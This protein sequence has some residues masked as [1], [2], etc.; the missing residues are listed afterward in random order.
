M[1]WPI[2]HDGIALRVPRDTKLCTGSST[3]RTGLQIKK[4][5]IT[6]DNI[7]LE[8]LCEQIV[9]SKIVWNIIQPIV[10][11][12]VF[13]RYMATGACF[14]SDTNLLMGNAM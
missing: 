10:S 7:A 6:E 14:A 11:M 3:P 4:K 5:Y 12:M 8:N 2:R 13:D 1:Q 9:I